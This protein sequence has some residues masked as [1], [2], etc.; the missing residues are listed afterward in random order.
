MSIESSYEYKTWNL[1]IP[2]FFMTI[3][4]LILSIISYSCVLFLF[5]N[6]FS[7]VKF[8]IESHINIAFYL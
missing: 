8:I 5:D 7:A 1:N 6:F 2:G 4:W 3:I